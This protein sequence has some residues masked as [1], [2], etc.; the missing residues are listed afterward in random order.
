MHGGHG[1]RVLRGQRG[2]D[3]QS[4]NAVGGEGAKVSLDPRAAAGVG[5]G[6]AERTWPVSVAL[7]R[8]GASDLSAIRPKLLA[9]NIDKLWRF[10]QPVAR[11]QQASEPTKHRDAS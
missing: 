3:A 2:D 6:D 8:H 1:T 11:L 10:C 7:A 4:V 5:A 9:L